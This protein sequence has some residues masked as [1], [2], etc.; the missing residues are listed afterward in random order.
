MARR[1]SG[2][3]AVPYVCTRNGIPASSMAAISVRLS[4]PPLRPSTMSYDEAYDRRTSC[5]TAAASAASTGSAEAGESRPR[6]VEPS[7][8]M[9][10]RCSAGS[11]STPSNKARSDRFIDRHH[12]AATV[13]G[14][15]DAGWVG[16]RSTRV[17][18]ATPP[19]TRCQYR[20]RCSNGSAS[21][22]T[23]CP[24]HRISTPWACGSD[25]ERMPIVIEV[26]DVCRAV[27]LR[28]ST[29]TWNG[30][31][32]SSVSPCDARGNACIRSASGPT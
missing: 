13:A 3:V 26:A 31:S 28:A 2:M 24:S 16:S 4:K 23:C 9:V 14:Q 10:K 27:V 30:P 7:G 25:G 32:G 15:H 6:C 5:S 1:T 22:T 19:P 29:A 8:P 21:I 18:K 11:R 17:A 12:C 20:R